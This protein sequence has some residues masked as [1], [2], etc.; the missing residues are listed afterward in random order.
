MRH[1]SWPRSACSW[2]RQ[3]LLQGE[4]L[5][6]KE[7]GKQR[8]C[9]DLPEWQHL[10]HPLRCQLPH[11]QRFCRSV[12]LDFQTEVL[13]WFFLHSEGSFSLFLMKEFFLKKKKKKKKKKS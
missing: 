11:C 13:F 2:L 9:A 1:Q 7:L 12:N 3:Q 5:V 6:G 10:W 8:I 4:E